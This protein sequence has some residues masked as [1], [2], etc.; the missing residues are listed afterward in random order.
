MYLG[1]EGGFFVI[2]S[3]SPL[4]SDSVCALVT[5]IWEEILSW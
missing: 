4:S 2:L 1:F 5:H 3:A